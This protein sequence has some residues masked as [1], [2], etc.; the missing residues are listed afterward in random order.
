ME[1]S[2]TTL[3]STSTVTHDWEDIRIDCSMLNITI[4][5]SNYLGSVE[6]VDERLT[7]EIRLECSHQV[8]KLGISII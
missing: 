4:S 5:Y 7:Q 8:C 1:G 3:D 2:F 6:D